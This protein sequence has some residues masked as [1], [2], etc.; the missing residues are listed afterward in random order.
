M[1]QVFARTSE[2]TASD[3][4]P[5]RLNSDDDMELILDPDFDGDISDCDRHI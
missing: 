1:L 4:K 3:S 2:D 5:Q